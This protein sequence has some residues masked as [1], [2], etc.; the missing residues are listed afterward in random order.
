MQFSEGRIRIKILEKIRVE[1]LRHLLDSHELVGIVVELV[2]DRVDITVLDRLDIRK[3]G[4]F[5][6]GFQFRAALFLG[7]SIAR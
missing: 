4:T 2:P 7:R 3:C 1:P 5:R 6:Q